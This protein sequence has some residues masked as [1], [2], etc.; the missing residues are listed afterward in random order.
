M[1]IAVTSLENKKAGEVELNESVFGLPVR[2]DLLA[3][4]VNYQLA[5]RRAGTHKV[6]E[7]GEVRGSTRKI[8]NQKG[9][10]ARHG[11]IRANLF[12]GGGITHGPRVQDHSHDLPKKVRLLALKTALSAKVAEGKLVVLDNSEVKEP[13]TSIL[14]KKLAALGWTSALVI[15]GATVNEGFARASRNIPCIDILPQQGANVFDILRRDTLVLTKDAVEAL[16]A[17]LK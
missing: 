2:A 4:M 15:D 11:S 8:K 12:R 10:G 6:K 9:G 3:R 17:R 5:K 13:K 14:V 1:K 16:E 7:R